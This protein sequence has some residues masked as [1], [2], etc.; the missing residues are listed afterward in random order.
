MFKKFQEL[1]TTQRGT[2]TNKEFLEL[3]EL[4]YTPF[5]RR[6]IDGFPL[7]A[8]AD[9]RALRNVRQDQVTSSPP[10]LFRS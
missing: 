8:D 3:P 4:R 1:D 5:R 7:K 10:H 2:L 9:V 6:L